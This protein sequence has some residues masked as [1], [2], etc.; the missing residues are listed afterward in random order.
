MTGGSAAAA[1]GM[2]APRLGVEL[3]IKTN[4]AVDSAQR[5]SGAAGDLHQCVGRQ[6]AELV[7]D[8]LEQ[9]NKISIRLRVQPIERKL[10]LIEGW[11]GPN[12]DGGGIGLLHT[13]NI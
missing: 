9:A 2:S 5:D 8:V 12:L 3:G 1:D 6:I 4:Y 13:F 7:L 10:D 11:F